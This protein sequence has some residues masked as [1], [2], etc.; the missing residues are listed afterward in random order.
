MKSIV[1]AMIANLHAKPDETSELI[2]EVLY[3][4]TVD[5]L[6]DCHEDWVYVQT[7]YRYKGYCQKADLLLDEETVP[8]NGTAK[9]SLSLFKA[10]QMFYSSLVSKAQS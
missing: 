1:T 3:G 10:L 7:A 4:M 2:D 9:H 6:T 8:L 5:I